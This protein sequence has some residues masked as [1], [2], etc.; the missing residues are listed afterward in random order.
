[1]DFYQNKSC[2]DF[3]MALSKNP[4][5]DAVCSMVMVKVTVFMEDCDNGRRGCAGFDN[6]GCGSNSF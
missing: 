5:T 1:M 4:F 3:Q 2:S 6:R